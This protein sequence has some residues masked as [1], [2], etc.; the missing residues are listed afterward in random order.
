MIERDP[1][2]EAKLAKAKELLANANTKV[3]PL[4]KEIKPLKYFS[5]HG[6]ASLPPVSWLIN[7]VVPAKGLVSL[8]GACSSFKTFITLDLCLCIALGIDY[9]GIPTMQRN[10]LYI[11]SEGEGDILDRV[12]AWCIGKGVDMEDLEGKVFFVTQPAPL[13]ADGMLQNIYKTIEEIENSYQI[14]IGLY[15][16]DT[17]N[18]NMVGDE[19]STRDMTSFVQACDDLR[20]HT[21]ATVLLVHHT[22][23][24]SSTRARGSS[25]LV[26]AVDAELCIV[27]EATKGSGKKKLDSAAKPRGDLVLMWVS[28]LRSGKDG[29]KFNF[30]VERIKVGAEEDRESIY[31]VEVQSAPMEEESEETIEPLTR[32]EQLLYHIYELEETPKTVADIQMDDRSSKTI[33]RQVAKLRKDGHLDMQLNITEKGLQRL[34]ELNLITEGEAD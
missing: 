18:R 6:L 23:Y 21:G 13:N 14:K 4:A 26:S 7:R 34:M 1:E 20:V 17:V 28:K 31:L 25:A 12:Q 24:A 5:V 9:F 16:V 22:G 2:I 27:R 10:V 29:R 19:N 32:T 15:T 3:A 8:F 33:Y 30:K 11:L